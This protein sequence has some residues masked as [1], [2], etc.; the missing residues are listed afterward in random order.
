MPLLLATMLQPILI[1]AAKLQFIF[2]I[3][4]AMGPR[5][6]TASVRL[7]HGNGLGSHIAR[8]ERAPQAAAL[9]ARDRDGA[10]PRKRSQDSAKVA[11]SKRVAHFDWSS[12]DVN[13]RTPLSQI[14]Q[15]RPC[16][17]GETHT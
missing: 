4:T 13:F 11:S 1:R 7:H 12:L 3:A 10:G 5:S 2:A 6:L 9:V 8:T 16:R 15:A 17:S 14:L